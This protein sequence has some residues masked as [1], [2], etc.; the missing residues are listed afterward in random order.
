MN[1]KKLKDIPCLAN[2]YGQSIHES[3][4]INI[5]E[6]LMPFQRNLF[7]KINELKQSNRWKHIW[8]VNGKVMLRQMDD[9]KVIGLTMFKDFQQFRSEL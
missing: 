8:T 7:G 3:N 2:E 4:T 5:N 1:G 9:S 6:S